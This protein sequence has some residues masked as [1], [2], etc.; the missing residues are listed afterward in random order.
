MFLG[1]L[2]VFELRFLVTNDRNTTQSGACR[3]GDLGHGTTKLTSGVSFRPGWI[4][5]LGQ[6][7]TLAI[8]ELSVPLSDPHSQAAR[9]PSWCR[10]SC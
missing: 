4:Q 10:D 5:V 7:M 9:P 6:W 1:N 8:T 3:T 2:L